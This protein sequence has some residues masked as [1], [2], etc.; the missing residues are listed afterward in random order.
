MAALGPAVG[1]EARDHPAR[2]DPADLLGHYIDPDPLNFSRWLARL[3]IV[4]M[5]DHI[6]AVSECSA[7]DAVE[8]LGFDQNRITVID[9]GTSVQ[10]A[11]MVT[12]RE[13]AAKILERQFPGIC[14][15][16]PS[17][18]AGATGARTSPA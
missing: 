7:A 9:A 14:D 6:L 13:E 11:S 15:D 8:H 18:S 3:G 16:S 17:T 10:M 4:R 1:R 5:A 12:T 2:P